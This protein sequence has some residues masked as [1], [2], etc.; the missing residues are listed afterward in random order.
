MLA[1]SYERLGDVVT[2]ANYLTRLVETSIRAEQH[3]ITSEAAARLGKLYSNTG[4]YAKSVN[5][6]TMA[7]DKAKLIHDLTWLT[8]CQI[9]LGTARA[10]SMA[11]IYQR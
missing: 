11:G 1:K 3:Q 10:R 6:Y 4:E 7:F 8:E 5:W 9:E 2:A